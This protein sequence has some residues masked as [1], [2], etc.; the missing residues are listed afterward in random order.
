MLLLLSQVHADEWVSAAEV[1]GKAT[2]CCW[3]KFVSFVTL[4][5]I[6]LKIVTKRDT[7]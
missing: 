1:Q 3:R 2:N 6:E 4:L 7:N 5:I